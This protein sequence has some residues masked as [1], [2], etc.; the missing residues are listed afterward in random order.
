MKIKEIK[1]ITDLDRIKRS[2]L[3]NK[4]ECRHFQT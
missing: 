1:S 4:N 3:I 2:N